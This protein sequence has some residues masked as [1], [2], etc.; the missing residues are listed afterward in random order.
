LAAVALPLN[1]RNI[2]RVGRWLAVALLVAQFGAETHL[3]SHPL[4]DAPDKF[5][6][7]RH[8]GTCLASSQL[9]NAVAPPALALPVRS[10]AWVTLVAEVTASEFHPA[11]FRAF[12][13]RAPPS[14]A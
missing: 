11:P 4:S 1:R 2:G 5:G 13:S 3:Y 9:Q 8:C 14:L 10:I 6:A 12:R 7:A